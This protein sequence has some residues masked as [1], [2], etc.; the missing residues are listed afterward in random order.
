MLLFFVSFA[1]QY[2]FF[3]SFFFVFC[4]RTLA[5][6]FQIFVLVK[7][8]ADLNVTIKRKKKKMSAFLGKAEKR[9]KN[10]RVA[11]C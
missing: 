3:L 2:A 1:G 5:F 4:F 7:T 10:A 6:L 11:F 8:S 9:Y